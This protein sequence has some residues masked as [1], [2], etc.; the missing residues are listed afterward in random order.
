MI[1]TIVAVRDK[2]CDCFS[3]PFFAQTPAAAIRSFN[4][5]VNRAAQDNPYYQHPEDYAL[6]EL[7]QYNDQDGSI[8]SH[9]LPKLL[10]QADQTVAEKSFHKPFTAV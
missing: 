6:Y 4:D 10:I 8:N 7:G 9:L 2:K 1:M 5:E 3:R